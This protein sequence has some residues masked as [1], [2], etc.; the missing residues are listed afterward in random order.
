[1]SKQHWVV[2]G[3]IT[4][5]PTLALGLE[6]VLPL[7]SRTSPDRKKPARLEVEFYK[8][9]KLNYFSYHLKP[10]HILCGIPFLRSSPTDFRFVVRNAGGKAA[11]WLLYV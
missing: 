5:S 2:V 11:G 4:C 10:Y 6:E 9:R 1:M 7:L 8:C 3:E